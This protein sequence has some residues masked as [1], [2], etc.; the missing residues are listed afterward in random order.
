MH[1]AC[2]SSSTTAAATTTTTTTPTAAAA[3]AT[4]TAPPA[5]ADAAAAADSN[6][7]FAFP[8]FEQRRHSLGKR[9]RVRSAGS[10]GGL[11]FA[12]SSWPELDGLVRGNDDGIGPLTPPDAGLVHKTLRYRHPQFSPRAESG[13][14]LLASMNGKRGLWFC[15]AW[16][17]YGFHEV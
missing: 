14:R 9:E 11:G 2:S 5:L 8:P 1:T 17:G 13:Q 6:G 7:G 16:T 4:A 10:D 15:G 3:V 12:A